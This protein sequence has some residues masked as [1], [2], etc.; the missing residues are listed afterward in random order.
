MNIKCLVVLSALTMLH[1]CTVAMTIP[2][3]FNSYSGINFLFGSCSVQEYYESAQAC[4]REFFN[5]VRVDRIK[6]E[7]CSSLYRDLK[8]CMLRV[9][10]ECLNNSMLES[11]LFQYDQREAVED[12]Y[13]T[14]LGDER[15]WCDHGGISS[16]VVLHHG[17]NCDPIYSHVTK[18]CVALYQLVFNSQ[19]SQRRLCR[20][21][22]R[23]QLCIFRSTIQHC[24]FTTRPLSQMMRL[25]VNMELSYQ[26]YCHKWFGEEVVSYYNLSSG[27]VCPPR[28]HADVMF[29][30]DVSEGTD[31]GAFESMKSAIRRVVDKL[32]YGM[33]GIRAGFA[34]FD[35]RILMSIRM[36]RYSTG[37]RFLRGLS[38]TERAA[39]RTG[40]PRM[41][42]N[43]LSWLAK[44]LY[45]NDTDL[46]A[47]RP[48]HT[49]V[50]VVMTTGKS[51]D[52]VRSVIKTLTKRRVRVILI[53][54]HLTN[55]TSLHTI[56]TRDKV[57]FHDHCGNLL[58]EICQADRDY[59]EGSDDF[60]P[61]SFLFENN[62][63]LNSLNRYFLRFGF[64]HLPLLWVPKPVVPQGPMGFN[65]NSP[66]HRYIGNV[67]EFLDDSNFLEG[68]LY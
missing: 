22:N 63:P 64:T 57:S 14:F 8:T 68:E 66:G 25:L 48:H 10:N 21:Y 52:Q 27:I 11:Y 49:P 61:G 56:Q 47:L 67:S 19:A 4:R 53:G 9:F 16:P 3:A 44:H 31:D 23:A 38:R 62:S 59:R 50:C 36:N 34:Q 29:L 28:S 33:N 17:T 13:L 24:S 5:S 26:P 7:N 58:Q 12:N 45:V 35:D 55:S 30:A 40:A 1:A 54:P 39:I 41:T 60:G 15:R 65:S 18:D 46:S 2:R 6:S 42:G 43:A 51:Q 20:E 32:S 37:K